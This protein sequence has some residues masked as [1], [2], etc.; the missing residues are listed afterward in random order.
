VALAKGISLIVKKKRKS[1]VMP[2]APRI[3]SHLMFLPKNGIP[4]FLIQ[5]TQMVKEITDRKN[6][7]SCVGM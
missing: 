2:V 6:T 5:K 7:I 1:A 4:N 3:K